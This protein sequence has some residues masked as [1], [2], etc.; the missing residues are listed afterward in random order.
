ITLPGMPIG[1]RITAGA[2]GIDSARRGVA[3][4]GEQGPELMMMKGGETV[5]P[6][7]QT[8]ALLALA[9]KM[10]GITGYAGGTGNV[11][12]LEHQLARELAVIVQKLL[13]ASSISGIGQ[14][15]GNLLSTIKQ[16]TADHH[17]GKKEES[18]I[19]RQIRHDNSHLDKLFRERQK[20]LNRI[21]AADAYAKNVSQAAQSSASLSTIMGSAGGG[22]VSSAF[23]LA[24]MKI[25]LAG[26][27]RFD[28]D[29]KKLE[30][31]GLDK[32]LLN[33]IIQMGPVQGDQAAQALINGP[34][35]NIKA[36][37]ATESQVQKASRNLGRS[38]ADH[39]FDAGKNAGK[40]F[41]SG[42]KGEEAQIEKLMKHLAETMAG[43][44]R[45]E[46]GLPGGGHGHHHHHRHLRVHGGPIDVIGGHLTQALAA[47]MPERLPHLDTTL[48]GAAGHV[49]SVLGSAAGAG[50]GG[51]TISV[52]IPV[53]TKLDGKAIYQSVQTQTL[54]VNRRNPD[55]RLSL[56][57]GRG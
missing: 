15:T 40:G 35:S 53:E 3:L 32:A 41:L 22:P 36:L 27:R 44:L 6:H 48:R 30:K 26:I 42:L 8:K 12:Q 51:I 50:G 33:Q 34:L 45:R 49:S 23:L 9:G 57:R 10:H 1:T 46:L 52:T 38:T 4:V 55:N 28:A 5:V 31:L 17:I 16:L 47:G 29:I 43:T 13:S 20:I 25:D 54:R 14:L 24:S 37:N 56:T 21:K 18:R 11:K 2:K 19:V 7:D 39:M